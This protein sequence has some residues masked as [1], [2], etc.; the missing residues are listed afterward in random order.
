MWPSPSDSLCSYFYLQRSNFTLKISHRRNFLLPA[1][2]C[3]SSICY[4]IL[5]CT[6]P[7]HMGYLWCNINLHLIET[8]NSRMDGLDRCS[9][10]L[11]INRKS[12]YLKAAKKQREEPLRQWSL[13]ILLQSLPRSVVPDTPPSTRDAH[14]EVKAAIFLPHCSRRRWIS[15]LY[16]RWLPVYSGS[17][18]SFAEFCEKTKQ[19]KQKTD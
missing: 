15:A 18:C 8:V 17:T 14:S 12:L 13:L 1:W 5:R 10:R 16:V 3:S 7:V 4:L 11:Q 19:T 6:F 9:K 2:I